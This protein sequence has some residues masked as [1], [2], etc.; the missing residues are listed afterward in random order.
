M[1]RS[2]AVGVWT[3]AELDILPDDGNEYELVDGELT[4]TPA[5]SVSHWRSTS[6]AELG[7]TWS[8]IPMTVPSCLTRSTLIF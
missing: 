6:S 3:L 5:P 2:Q 7:S 1:L 8:P 4:V